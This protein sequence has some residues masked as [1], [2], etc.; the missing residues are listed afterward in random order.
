MV[1]EPKL[2]DEGMS[3]ESEMIVESWAIEA[4]LTDW[5]MS[6]EKEMVDQG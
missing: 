3:L 5:G 1:I 4:L 2:R 6:L